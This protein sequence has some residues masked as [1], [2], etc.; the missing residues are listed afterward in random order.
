MI[1]NKFIYFISSILILSGCST[2]TAS[3]EQNIQITS[4]CKNKNLTNYCIATNAE[5]STRFTTPNT[6][7]I[8][9][10][11]SVLNITCHSGSF[12]NASKNIKSKPGALIAGNIIFGGVFG[13]II[14]LQNSHTYEYPNSINIEPQICSF[15]K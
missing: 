7:K 5:G 13:S 9:K 3:N 1:N 11:S 2:L 6:I 10:S 4:N 12:N 15:I 8:K 14:D